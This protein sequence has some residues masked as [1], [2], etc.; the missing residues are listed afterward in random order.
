[1]KSPARG[2]NTS[3]A[4]VLGITPSGVWILVD[5]REYFMS[6]EDYPWFKHAKV[7]DV[8]SVKLLRGHHL[9]WESLDVDLLV[10]SLQQPESY[11]LRWKT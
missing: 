8:Q 11:P 4:E 6:F 2:K 9:R 10:E 5:D 3:K 7:S 1:M